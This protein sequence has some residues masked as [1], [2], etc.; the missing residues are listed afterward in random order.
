MTPWLLAAAVHIQNGR[1]AFRLSKRQKLHQ[2][3]KI[4]ADGN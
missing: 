1:I 2:N 3:D 4:Y